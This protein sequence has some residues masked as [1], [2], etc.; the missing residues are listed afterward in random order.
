[1][2]LLRGWMVLWLLIPLGAAHAAARHAPPDELRLALEQLAN[3]RGFSARFEQTIVFR[4]GGEQHYRGEVAVLRPGRFRWHYTAPYEQLYVG[5][6]RRIWHYEPDL[7]QVQVMRSLQGVD[8]TVMKLLNGDVDPRQLVVI[9]VA[10]DADGLRRYHA[11]IGGVTVWIGLAGVRLACVESVDALGN[12]NRIRL[13]DMRL[14]PPAA[15]L[16]GFTPP[17]GVDVLR[18]E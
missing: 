8:P 12:R 16:F 11:R 2:T 4:E 6:G 3:A 17:A 1:M 9:D 10:R 7:M 15:R 18:L 14:T 5:D 13:L